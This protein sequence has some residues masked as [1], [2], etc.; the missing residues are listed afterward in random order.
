MNEREMKIESRERYGSAN[1][2]GKEI[3]GIK[4]KFSYR[5][6]GVFDLD[7]RRGE[8]IEKDK[9]VDQRSTLPQSKTKIGEPRNVLFVHQKKYS[10]ETEDQ[11]SLISALVDDILNGNI[12]RK[13]FIKLVKDDK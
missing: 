12:S 10:K 2:W 4:A 3:D 5:G 8:R 9:K 7:K 1:K 11:L 13:D 6:K